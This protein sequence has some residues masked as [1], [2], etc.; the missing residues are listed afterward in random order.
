MGSHGDG[1]GDP[2]KGGVTIQEG[3]G[4]HCRP[5]MATMAKMTKAAMS[6]KRKKDVPP[7]L[8]C[9]LASLYGITATVALPPV[10]CSHQ[11]ALQPIYGITSNLW[12]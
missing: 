11:L 5:A 10:C 6:S 1:Q 7:W 2:P 9:Q 4:T 3:L 12:H 8:C